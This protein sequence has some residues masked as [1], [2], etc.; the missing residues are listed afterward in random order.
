MSSTFCVHS[1]SAALLAVEKKFGKKMPWET[2]NESQ[3]AFMELHGVASLEV[4]KIPEITAIAGSI[5]EI[6]ELVGQNQS[7]VK[8]QDVKSKGPLEIPFALF[9]KF[10]VSVGWINE[11]R[12]EAIDWK[13]SRD[14]FGYPAVSISGVGVKF[15]GVD[16]YPHIIASL[17]T[18]TDYQVLLVRAKKPLEGI[19]LYKEVAELQASMI[20]CYSHSGVKFPMTDLLDEPDISWFVDMNSRGPV[21]GMPQEDTVVTIEGAKQENILR[22]NEVGARVRSITT[23]RGM[24]LGAYAADTPPPPLIIEEP[25]Y[26]AITRED[27]ELPLFVAHVTEENWKKP[28]SLTDLSQ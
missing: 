28:A 18:K 16:G 3:K 13:R 26:L 2:V 24:V 20:P 21:E 22:M 8:L 10:D 17:A 14:D 4:P 9:G 7:G 25:Y 11:G 19:E 23:M 6:N 15:F 12:P 5:D 1:A 27:C